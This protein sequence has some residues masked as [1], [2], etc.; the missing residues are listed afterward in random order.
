MKIMNKIYDEIACEIAE[1]WT[2]ESDNNL[3]KERDENE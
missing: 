1:I 2:L 3:E